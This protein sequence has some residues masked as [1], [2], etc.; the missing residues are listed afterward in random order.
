MTG[1]INLIPELKPWKEAP[2]PSTKDEALNIIPEEILEWG[3]GQ[4]PASEHTRQEMKA[5]TS[6]PQ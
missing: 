5:H 2:L 6:Y 3:E 4:F 1:M